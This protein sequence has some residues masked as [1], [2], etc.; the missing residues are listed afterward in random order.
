M[1]G[2]A[3]IPHRPHVRKLL[4]VV[5]QVEDWSLL[6][7]LPWPPVVPPCLAVTC[8]APHRRPSAIPGIAAHLATRKPAQLTSGRDR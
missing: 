6:S 8:P 1:Q 5:D 7:S 3:W 2:R 4:I